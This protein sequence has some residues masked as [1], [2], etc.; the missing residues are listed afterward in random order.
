MYVDAVGWSRE[1]ISLRGNYGGWR[2]RRRHRIIKAKHET[3]WGG[4][5]DK[6]LKAVPLGKAS[7]EESVSKKAELK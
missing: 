6:I 1:E 4:L 5:C 7:S 2:S 3:A